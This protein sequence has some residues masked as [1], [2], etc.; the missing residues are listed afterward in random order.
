MFVMRDVRLT[1]GDR[2]LLVSSNLRV[3]PGEVVGLV[4]AN[5]CGKSTLLRTVCGTR[6]VDAGTLLIAQNADVGYLEQTA[7]SGSRLTVAEEAKSRMTHVRDAEQA[8]KDAE[9]AIESSAKGAEEI[10]MQAQARFE[11]VGGNSVE[12][13]V[14]DVL[15]G[16]GFAREA[17][18][19]PCA[20][21]SGGWQ[22]RVA[23]ARLLLSP[24]GDTATAG[25]TGG[26]LLLDEPTN[27]LDASAKEFLRGWL[28]S[29]KGTAL[30][31]SH[32]EQLL[33]RG[34][35][36][37]VEV[38]QQK[39]FTYS[40]NYQRFLSE[41]AERRKAA[42]SALE[43]ESK[44]AAKLEQFV[45]RNSA[46]ASTAASAKSRAKQ[47]VGVKENL[48]QLAE[49]ASG[50]DEDDAGPGDAKRVVL[51]LPPAPACAQECLVL[52]NATVGYSVDS[53]P[54]F[55]DAKITANL[56]D[57]ML[58]VGP[59]GAGKSTLL[60]TL[61]GQIRCQKGGLKH[62]EGVRV[63][64]FS[65]DL[66]QELPGEEAP[67]S[68]VLRVARV[69]NPTVTMQTAR[70]VL[71]ALGLTGN[72]VVDRTINDLSGG[73]KARVALAAFVLR[74]VN[75][76]LLDEASN[77]LDVAAL[78]ALTE[79]LRGWNGAV[80]AVTHNK[81]FAEALEPT[82]VVRVEAGKVSSRMTSGTL[83]KKDFSPNA[84]QTGGVAGAESKASATAVQSPGDFA[85]GAESEAEKKEKKQQRD[86]LLKEARNAPGVIV[87]IE[88]ALAVIDDDV[89][90]I[91]QKM[92]ACGSDVATAQEVQ[93][94]RD[95]KTNKAELYYAEWERLEEV[96]AQAEEIL[97]GEG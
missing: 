96:M 86:K 28:K 60:R 51:K 30:V 54:L 71:G 69:A 80:I 7:V 31:V 89:A 33:E 65:Q 40:G 8:L 72:T 88:K 78:D 11:S 59:N 45:A 79:A 17:W 36:R 97:E 52:E 55:T 56:G 15:T 95:L 90:A 13:R 4:G 93:K 38:R 75:V 74:P 27:H 76:L 1:V 21:L 41:R 2:D 32:D 37:L 84:E 18:D 70:S 42:V 46:R 47:L 20:A 23:L 73:E 44:K 3:E 24:A 10:F 77:H 61:N 6:D 14:S 91:D 58:V 5:G 85:A 82:T 39:L 94:E 67:L 87:K 66:A 43:K 48:E 64:Y 63:G 16:L 34:V 22:M 9:Q 68:H 26:F 49:D 25:I 57:R 12:R 35:D 92:L 53:K 29:Y 81:A 62:G 83:S 50:G 19:R